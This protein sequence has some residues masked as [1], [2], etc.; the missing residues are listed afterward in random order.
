MI[1]AYPTLGEIPFKD[2]IDDSFYFYLICNMETTFNHL[3]YDISTT[4]K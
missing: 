3:N 1:V 2:K 4:G